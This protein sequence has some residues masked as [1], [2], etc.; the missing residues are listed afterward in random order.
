MNPPLRAFHLAP[1]LASILVP[2][3]ELAAQVVSAG[4]VI[5]APM[6]GVRVGGVTERVDGLWAGLVL[7]V[8]VGRFTISGTATRG[9]LT[10]DA[11][12]VPPRAVG[13]MSL[14]GRYEFRPW[15]GFDLRYAA[16]A[17][18]SAA[19]F[20]RWNYVG[21]GVTASRNLGTPS[22]RA[23]ASLAYM[24]VVTVTGQERSPFAVAGDVGLSLAP[25]RFPITLQLNYRI[26]RFR[27]PGA[28]ARSEQFE[29]LALS[30]GVRFRRRDGRW[31]VGG[32]EK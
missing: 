8:R 16:R 28:V 12:A 9:Q 19:G 20:Q 3:A 6:S 31:R 27:F 21:V 22:V 7:D 32:T 25:N 23:F 1:L 5:A 14:S 18:S 4:A 15:L 24:P 29:A 17:F 2:P 11:S 10:G 30:V 13:E 26:E